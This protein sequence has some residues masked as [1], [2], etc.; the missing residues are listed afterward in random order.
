MEL[1]FLTDTGRVQNNDYL[2]EPV[3]FFT[4]S[5]G[6]EFANPFSISIPITDDTI[7]E[8]EERIRLDI[9]INSTADP[10]YLV[11][12]GLILRITDNDG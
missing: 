10:I 11:I 12:T 8:P 6:E 5:A 9:S 3:Y 2:A 1:I 7:V 4:Y